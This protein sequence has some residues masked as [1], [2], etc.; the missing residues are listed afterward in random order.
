MSSPFFNVAGAVPDPLEKVSIGG[1]GSRPLGKKA[2]LGIGAAGTGFPLS[3]R[4]KDRFPGAAGSGTG[5]AVNVP[6]RKNRQKSK[7]KA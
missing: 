2:G 6:E 1:H 5:L 7:D 4:P 3:L